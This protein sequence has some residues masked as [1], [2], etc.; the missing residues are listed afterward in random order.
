MRRV[1]VTGIGGLVGSAVARELAAHQ[2]TV[3]GCDN[4][5]R[6]AWFGGAG[7]VQWRIDQ[8][9]KEGVE[10]DDG[11]VIG[12]VHKLK[13]VE[14]I[15]HCAGQPSHDYSVK[16]PL[17]DTEAN[18]ISTLFMLEYLRQHNKGASVVFMST[19]KVYGDRVNQC[20]YSQQGDRFVPVT[21]SRWI[22]ANGV[23]EL[24]STDGCRHT[25][26][27]VS[28]L[29][30]DLMV[31]EYWLRYR[32]PTVCFRCGCITGSER[33]AVELH[34]FLGYLAKCAA[35]GQKYTVYGHRGLQVRDN[36]SADDLAKLTRI[37]LDGPVPGVYN[38][39]GGLANSLSVREAVNM[40][41]TEFGCKFE[42]DWHGPA[43][44]GDHMWW[45]SD[46]TCLNAVYPM[47]R[48]RIGVKEML[49][50]MVES[51]RSDRTVEVGHE[52]VPTS[53]EQ[54]EGVQQLTGGGPV[55]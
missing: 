22:C 9:R 28:K 52:A 3:S 11:T 54:S 53:T 14:A 44:Y 27:G 51:A 15:V 42:V 33:S 43:R 20:H 24:C 38:V 16:E 41:R 21:T 39:G 37:W 19:N 12:T 13:G 31:Q 48:P 29:A 55:E 17:E 35:T 18:Y 5:A 26:F 46:M 7:S 8:L 45:V 2:W 50:A 47:W 36:L 32:I 4:N 25:P 23:N 10:V 6:G 30:A 49:N 1:Y 34:G 40:L